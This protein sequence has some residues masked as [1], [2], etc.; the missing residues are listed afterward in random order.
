MYGSFNYKRNQLLCYDFICELQED[1]VIKFFGQFF[2]VKIKTI[3]FLKYIKMDY[4]RNQKFDK[5]K[6]QF[7]IIIHDPKNGNI[8]IFRDQVGIVPLYYLIQDDVMYFG[9]SIKYI[10][11]M[12]NVYAQINNS[13]IH[14]YISFRYISGR[15]TLFKG[16]KEVQPGTIISIDKTGKA[17]TRKYFQLN[18]TI[19]Y[20]IK[21]SNAKSQ[22]QNGFLNGLYS[23]F[24]EKE[25]RKIGILL[26]GG[27]DSSILVGAAPKY[28]KN[29]LRSYY[30]GNVEYKYNRHREAEIIS[31]IYKTKHRNVFVS[32]EEYANNL[33]DTIRI[34]EE[35]L[36]HPSSVL[37]YY[38]NK[39]IKNEVDVLLTGEGADCLYCG[40][41]IF[42]LIRYSYVRNPLK[43]ISILLDGLFSAFP[44]PKKYKRKCLKVLK[45]FTLMPDEYLLSYSDL[46]SLNNDM[47]G[48]ILNFEL[49]NNFLI[50]YKQYFTR[51]NRQNVLETIL[52]IYQSHYLIEALNTIAKLGYAFGLDFYHP[53]LDLDLVNSFNQFAW[54]DKIKFFKRKHQVIELG[55]KHLP[56]EFFNKKKEGFGVPLSTLFYDKRGLRRYID[57]LCDKKTKERG[58][59]NTR[60]LEEQLI[61]YNHKGMPIE[62]FESILWPIINLELWFRI[63][64][65]KDVRGYS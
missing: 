21:G 58:V 13:V 38:L 43:N 40:Y 12:A 53:F 59:F 46:V 19:N 64:I 41:Y 56:R 49:P 22:F 11:K 48:D 37:R 26:S 8:H 44:I 25:N 27:I 47:T 45:S 15:N 62:S 60:F 18:Y 34:N 50:N 7:V 10:L 51:Y 32:S 5:L 23:Q 4:Y 61:L 52:L 16:I 6:G 33:I 3:E 24:K 14:E 39:T 55:K 20:E 30:I 35:P 1:I 17:K 28:F 9:I 63:F 54:K 36:N 57:L 2:P 29:K 65:D 42:D 31:R